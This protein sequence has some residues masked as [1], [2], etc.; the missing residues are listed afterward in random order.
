M[1][2]QPFDLLAR[3]YDWEHAE[4][5]GDLALYLGYAQRV[6]GPIFE[7]A[8]GSGRL[9][10]PLAEAG[11]EVVGLDASAAM[12][13]LAR[14]KLGGKPSRR[15]TELRQGDLRALKADRAYGL[16][17]LAL[18]GLGLLLERSDQLAA[19]AA[20]R[21][22][23]AHE[24]LL[25]VDV[26]NGN[27]RGGEA[28]EETVLQK[29]GPAIGGDGSIAKWVW[30]RTD[31]AAQVDRLLQIYDETD[32]T[33]IV[34]RTSVELSVRYFARFE[35]E[36]LLERAGLEIEALFG[37]YELTPYHATAPRLIAVAHAR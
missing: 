3:F 26:A 1:P 17:I 27:L 25:V 11:Y 30:R 28:A 5:A 14:A 12:L 16:A 13:D 22:L 21:S 23:L 33:G 34:R 36:L 10:L 2:E 37:D 18:D 29:A 19:L 7:A 8:C 9:L 31:H 35:L 4:F 6:G 24:G 20:L 15:R 32:A